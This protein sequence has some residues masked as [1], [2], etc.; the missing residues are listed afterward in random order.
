M[1]EMDADVLKYELG[2]NTVRTSHYPQSHYFID[3]CDEIGLL[4]ITEIPGWQHIGDE[5]WQDQAVKNVEEMILQY[6][7]HPSI[8]LWGVRINES[9]DNE[10]L[11]TKTNA[12]AHQLDPTRQTGGVRNFVK[13]QLLEDVYTFN[14]FIHDGKKPGCTPKA[15]VTPDVDKPYMVTEYNGHMYPTKSFDCEEHRV[16]HALRHATV[17]NAVASHTDIAGSCGWCMSDYNTHKDFG[18][19]DR[20]CYHGV[21]DMF[22]NPK[23]AAAVYSSQGSEPVLE[24]SSSMDIGEH[25]ACIK[26]DIWAFTNADSIKMYKNDRFITEYKSTYN[27]LFR[28]MNHSPILIDD[29]VGNAIVENEGLKPHQARLLK[30]IVN[31]IAR[32]GY[33]KLPLRILLKAAQCMLIYGM[34]YNDIVD[35]YTKHGGDWGG[36]STVYRFDAVMD[37]RVVA[38]VKKAPMTKASLR[39]NAYK[40]KLVEDRSYDVAAI[41]ISAVDENGNTL[42]FSNEPVSVSIDGPLQVVGPEVVSL[43]GGMA[44]VYVKT[45][46]EAGN[47]TVTLSSPSLGEVAI[48]FEIEK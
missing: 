12:L 23:L 13:S 47:A 10:E 4:V 6:R 16:E 21:T 34:K 42:V 24:I 35:F 9:R 20:I 15:I 37:G 31:Y 28:Y 38:S 32:N 2:L 25:P 11:Y 45:M 22:R 39:A 5:A 14:D 33:G 36:V 8:I 19:G 29:F 17:L 46:G 30:E 7:N 41:R 1:Q 43:R 44:G 18:S 26:G 40:T 48:D 3:R 27:K